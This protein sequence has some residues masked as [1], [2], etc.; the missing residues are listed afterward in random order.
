MYGSMCHMQSLATSGCCWASISRWAGAL[1]AQG[2]ALYQWLLASV[3]CLLVHSTI[4]Q[5]FFCYSWLLAIRVPHRK[6]PGNGPKKSGP[7]PREIQWDHPPMVQLCL[8][9]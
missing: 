9:C 2:Q 5:V 6:S 1:L 8:H 7:K 4:L 3:C